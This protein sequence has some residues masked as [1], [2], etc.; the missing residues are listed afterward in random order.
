MCRLGVE[1]FLEAQGMYSPSI[2]VLITHLSVYR[3]P[4]SRNPKPANQFLP[5]LDAPANVGVELP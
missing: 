2:A 1:D 5:G 4:M 3:P